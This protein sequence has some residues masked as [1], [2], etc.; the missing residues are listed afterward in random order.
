MTH[1][2]SASSP[3]DTLAT[4]EVL[5]DLLDRADQTNGLEFCDS[6]SILTLI[7]AMVEELTARAARAA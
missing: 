4:P 2:V 1:N 6:E 7:T 3:I 5:H